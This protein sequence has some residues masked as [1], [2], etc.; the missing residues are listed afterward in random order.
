MAFPYLPN[1]CLLLCLCIKFSLIFFIT[2]IFPFYLEEPFNLCSKTALCCT[3]TTAAPT[4][5]KWQQWACHDGSGSCK[6][7][8]PGDCSC[9]REVSPGRRG[10]EPQWCKHSPCF[11][12][13]SFR[14]V[15]LSHPGRRGQVWQHSW[16]IQSWSSHCAP[17][18]PPPYCSEDPFHM[19]TCQ[20]FPS[21]GGADGAPAPARSSFFKPKYVLGPG[22]DLMATSFIQNKV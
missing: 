6:M 7:P 20:S 14:R 4:L 17:A 15:I 9:R 2:Y 18:W 11:L 5:V 19:H 13:V 21:P 16:D 22:Q 1:P 3:G 12:G 10:S 8:D